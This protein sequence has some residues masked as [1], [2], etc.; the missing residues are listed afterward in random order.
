VC[1]HGGDAHV[2]APPDV[3]VDADPSCGCQGATLQCASSTTTCLLGCMDLTPG[4]RCIEVVPSNGVGIAATGALS[5]DIAIDAGI[6]TFDTDTGQIG[7]AFTRA[8]GPG[9]IADVAFELRTTGTQPIGVWTF[10]RLGVGAAGAV[11]FT[12][13]RSAVFVAGTTVTIGGLVDA[14]GGC[15]GGPVACAGPGGGVGASGITVANGCGPG[16]QGASASTG[17]GDGGGGGGGGRGAGAVGGLGAADGTAGVA[18]AACVAAIA[19]PLVGGA[20]GGAGSPGAVTRCS[21]GGGGG[22]LQITAEESIMI[23]G[24]ITLGGSGGQGGVGDPAGVNA[25][26]GCGG[27]AGGTLLVE[28]PAVTIGPTGVLAANGG[29][30]GGGASLGVPGGRG[31]TGA[32]SATPA[33]GGPPAN[34]NTVQCAGGG[35]GAAGAVAPVAGVASSGGNAGGGGGAIG[36]IYIRTSSNMLTSSGLTSPTPGTG[37]IRTN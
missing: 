16:G 6:A 30:G 19:E 4:A 21:G 3:A 35:A 15:Y 11:H 5:T 32:S 36:T 23:S 9:V 34:G 20:G 8:A 25:G 29:G 33:G 28:A 26:A 17:V 37:A 24:T 1:V 18:G 2:D 14:S 27:G 10:H 13:S 12:G 7:G 31:G 22:G